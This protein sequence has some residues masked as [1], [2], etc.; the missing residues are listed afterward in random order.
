MILCLDAGNTRLK[1]GLHDGQAWLAQAALVSREIGSVGEFVDAVTKQLPA[2]PNRLIACNVAGVAMR[3][4]IE[5]LAS[6]LQLTPQWLCSA[7][8]G[9]GVRNGYAQPTQLGHDRWTALI[10]ARGL[11]VDACVVVMAGTATTIDALDSA[12]RFRGGM[13]LP[14]LALMRQSL[15]GATAQLP[16]ASGRYRDWPDNTDDAI[17]SGSIAAT[18]GAIE[19]LRA[20]LG[21]ESVTPPRCVLSGGAADALRPLLAEPLLWQPELVL[22]G[23]RRAAANSQA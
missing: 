8:E 3:E 17:V 18:V 1:F 14:G 10:G 21:S 6:A 9:F 2:E 4:R 19:H 13:I 5:A 23:L 15:A 12:G 11:C 22:E 7:A 16:L 20:Q